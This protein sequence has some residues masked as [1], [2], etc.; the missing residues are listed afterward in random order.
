MNMAPAPDLLLLMSEA[1]APELSFSWLRLQL[2]SGV[3]SGGGDWGDRPPKTYE[4]NF[5]HHVLYISERHLTA[6]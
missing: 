1:L 4:S 5:S 3:D 6:N 2:L